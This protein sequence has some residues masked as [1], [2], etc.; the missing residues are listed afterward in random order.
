MRPEAL[1]AP[2]ADRP[3]PGAQEAVLTQLRAGL[4]LAH[5]L[6]LLQG[7]PGVG[8]TTVL[9][10]LMALESRQRPVIALGAQMSPLMVLRALAQ[11]LEL[12]D[13]PQLT[14]GGIA[15]VHERLLR[16]A[17][18]ASP[19]LVADD[20]VRLDPMV[21][22]FLHFW[23]TSQAARCG[24]L[25]VLLAGSEADLWKLRARPTMASLF[26]RAGA[27]WTLPPLAPADSAALLDRL[28][29]G[30]GL[31]PATLSASGRE[32]LLDW[33]QGIAGQLVHALQQIS[34][35]AAKRQRR[36]FGPRQLRTLL[37]LAPSSASGQRLALLLTVLAVVAAA[38]LGWQLQHG[39][40]FAAQPW[41]AERL[42]AAEDWSGRLRSAA[43][44]AA[45][46][47]RAEPDAD[48]APAPE[49]VPSLPPA[50]APPA[51]PAVDPAPRPRAAGPS[52]SAPTLFEGGVPGRRRCVDAEGQRVDILLWVAK[53]GD[54]MN[55]LLYGQD[56]MAGAEGRR[57]F[58]LLN[59]GVPSQGPIEPGT[60]LR[61]PL[62]R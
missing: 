10:R 15:Q 23:C 17:P 37:G 60:L 22:E 26:D 48:P 24:C 13:W 28:L 43:R 25:R 11:R 50:P 32:L 44:A 4:A 21:L 30:A 46:A 41:L 56:G 6:M 8:K 34:A 20:A 49:P 27:L 31:K 12:P 36:R 35:V 62:Q 19:L 61:I 52:C 45:D 2:L 18:D 16:V 38:A 59:P 51:A 5:P 33:A 54:T 53:P 9:R 55:S 14:L 3:L 29:A 7:E 57:R 1:A 58:A 39:L 47:L 42:D 40:P